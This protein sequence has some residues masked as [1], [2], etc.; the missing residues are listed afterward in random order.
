L[1]KRAR[2]ILD[3]VVAEGFHGLLAALTRHL[4]VACLVAAIVPTLASAQ[5]KGQAPG[6]VPYQLRVH[7]T[8]TDE[9]PAMNML[10]KLQ[11]PS[12]ADVDQF[13]TPSTGDVVFTGLHPGTYWLKVTGAGVVPASEPA[14][15]VG[16]VATTLAFV[17][18]KLTAVPGVVEGKGGLTAAVGLNVPPEARKEVEKGNKALTQNDPKEAKE[19]F[20]K[21][22][23]I[24]PRYAT[25]YHGLGVAEMKSGAIQEARAALQRA[26]SLDDHLVAAYIDLARLAHAERNYSD[27]EA[28]LEKSLVADPVNLVALSMLARARLLLG[29]W[30]Q[31]IADANKVHAWAGHEA[32]AIV[33]LIAAK[34]WEEKGDR[35]QAALEYEQFLKEAPNDGN[36]DRVRAALRSLQGQAR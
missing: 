8:Y 9:Q 4:S 7:V 15:I 26:I 34:A 18:L 28:L 31:A 3:A 17:R 30:D 23:E 27:A 20:Q 6:A 5:K 25:A 13:V 33:H 1:V 19:H 12:G 32:Y 21:A 24:Y 35:Q 16:G 10:V 36:A 11:G 2:A 29:K 14:D 22:T